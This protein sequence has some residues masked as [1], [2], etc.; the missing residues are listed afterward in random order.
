MG[1]GHS[2]GN[3]TIGIKTSREYVVQGMCKADD[4]GGVYHVV[5]RR[6]MPATL[7][8]HCTQTGF[9]IRQCYAECRRTMQLLPTGSA[10]LLGPLRRAS[11][12]H[13]PSSCAL[14]CTTRGSFSPRSLRGPVEAGAREQGPSF[15]TSRR[16]RSAPFPQLDS[17]D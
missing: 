3:N 13:I 9:Q 16:W 11:A 17:G 7:R 2:A 8:S 12:P 4:Q 1:P 15:P 6:K 14:S 5:T 10:T